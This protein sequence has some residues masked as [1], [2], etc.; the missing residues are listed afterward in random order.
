MTEEHTDVTPAE[1]ARR[2]GKKFEDLTEAEKLRLSRKNRE[3]QSPYG[4]RKQY[5]QY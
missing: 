4:R 3:R 1:K 5:K 2:L